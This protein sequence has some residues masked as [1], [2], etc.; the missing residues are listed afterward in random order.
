M[1]QAVT[2]IVTGA[3]E[4]ASSMH[5]AGRALGDMS[6]AHREAADIFAA[7][8]R[9]IAPGLTGALAAATEAASSKE[10]A[11]V[12]NALPYFGPI[13]YGWPAHNIVAQPYVDEAVADTEGQWLGVYVGAVQEACDL[14]RGV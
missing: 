3:D 8:A 5:R 11:G 12:H 14:V 9:A 10:G 7:Q 13:H 6:R 1:A 4:V 2:V